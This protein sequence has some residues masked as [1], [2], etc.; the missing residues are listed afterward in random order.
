MCSTWG[1]VK[2]NNY[3]LEVQKM[4]SPK[5]LSRP[6][7]IASANVNNEFNN[8]LKAMDHGASKNV[9]D[10]FLSHSAA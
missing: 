8:A 9:L 7:Y 1:G 2:N 10:K 3:H 5:L 6:P 4:E